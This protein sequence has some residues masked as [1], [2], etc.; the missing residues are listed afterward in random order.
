MLCKVALPKNHHGG[1]PFRIKEHVQRKATFSPTR[2]RVAHHKMDVRETI[3]VAGTLRVPR[4][5]DIVDAIYVKEGTTG[6][7]GLFLG[8]QLLDVR[9]PEAISERGLAQLCFLGVHRLPL[10]MYKWG[11]SGL[12]VHQRG[13]P[14]AQQ[15]A[16]PEVTYTIVGR[17]YVCLSDLAREEGFTGT[18]EEFLKRDVRF[19]VVTCG[20]LNYLRYNRDM[21]G[22]TIVVESR[23]PPDVFLKPRAS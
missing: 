8:G 2:P 19:P 9:E 1:L 13:E 7:F 14:G 17:K 10:L 20:M 15:G 11:F 22:C 21:A 16:K 12:T 4:S 3:T 18:V 5:F 23:D 6:V